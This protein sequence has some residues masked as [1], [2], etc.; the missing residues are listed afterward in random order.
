MT[1]RKTIGVEAGDTRRTTAEHI[2]DNGSGRIDSIC[3]RE[4]YEV[5]PRSVY[6]LSD[7]KKRVPIYS[8]VKR[9][10]RFCFIPLV[11]DVS[12]TNAH[13]KLGEKFLEKD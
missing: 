6:C 11:K 1:Y 12:E 3:K 10:A 5:T 9:N 2:T 4:G 13:L 7:G 8:P